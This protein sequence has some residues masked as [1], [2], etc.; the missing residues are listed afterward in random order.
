MKTITHILLIGVA[1]LTSIQI[2]A[3][4]AVWRDVPANELKGVGITENAER[5][6]Q[7]MD[8]A[9]KMGFG[10]AI[11]TFFH[12]EKNGRLVYGTV[13]IPKTDV[14]FKDIP[15]SEL[16]N[17]NLDDFAER[18]RQSM[19]WAAN[20]GHGAGIPTFYH[21]DNGRGVVYGTMLFKADR[22]SFRDIPEGYL[23]DLNRKD[24]ASWVRA[25][26]KYNNNRSNAGAFPTFHSADKPG[27]G[28]VYGVIFFKK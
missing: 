19:A 10:A 21:A 8:Y 6:R 4:E 14:E 17:V 28:L 3:Q 15:L 25:V 5:M 9:A 12:G 23:T 1:C 11:P 27:K 2:F 20:H 16:G 26:V 22:V 18:V 24:P 13:L 7:S